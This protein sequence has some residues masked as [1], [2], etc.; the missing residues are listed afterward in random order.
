MQKCTSNKGADL[1]HSKGPAHSSGWGCGLCLGP[2]SAAYFLG[3]VAESL[4]ALIVSSVK[5]T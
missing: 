4:C 1:D 2:G 3:Q 5:W